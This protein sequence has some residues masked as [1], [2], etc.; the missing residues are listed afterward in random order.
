V[1]KVETI[2]THANDSPLW[3]G[4]S[5]V[6]YSKWHNFIIQFKLTQAEI[7]SS[8]EEQIELYKSAIEKFREVLRSRPINFAAMHDL[9]FAL[10][11]YARSFGSEQGTDVDV[12]YPIL[13]EAINVLTTAVGICDLGIGNHNS[14]K[15]WND[16]KFFVIL[17]RKNL[18]DAMV[19]MAYLMDT[20]EKRKLQ[21][22]DALDQYELAGK[23]LDHNIYFKWATALSQYAEE[24]EGNHRN[25]LAILYL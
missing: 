9:G 6:L 22:M 21:F 18:A 1:D 17:A 19:N 20:K 8:R 25:I 15:Y 16:L 23:E 24:F 10:S 7:A 2:I 13:N 4:M 14:K 3:E 12:V 11:L 5:L